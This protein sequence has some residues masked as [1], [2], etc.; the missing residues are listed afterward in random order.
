M[1]G[2][3]RHQTRHHPGT[4]PTTRCHR[5]PPPPPPPQ[6]RH[7][8]RHHRRPPTPA[9]LR[10]HHNHQHHCRRHRRCD[11]FAHFHHFS[12][13]HL[14]RRHRR[15]HHFHHYRRQHRCHLI[16]PL[17]PGRTLA[18]DTMVA[19]TS[20]PPPS[21]AK[22][23]RLVEDFIQKLAAP[24]RTGD[25]SKDAELK[26]VFRL[27]GQ[28]VSGCVARPDAICPCTRPTRSTCELQSRSISPTAHPRSSSR[29]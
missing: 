1:F 25:K 21:P 28:V 9:R 26:S 13:Q 2:V 10:H 14:C 4:P 7:H 3:P 24:S 16:K 12:R 6:P 19:P 15:C 23:G 20:E 17:P 27:L 8:H 22:V 18:S 11:H 29:A 5:S